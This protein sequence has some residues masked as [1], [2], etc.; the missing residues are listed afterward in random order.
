[1]KRLIDI[2][3]ATILL[4][5]LCP[6]FITIAVLIKLETGKGV[7]FKQSRVGKKGAEFNIYKFRSMHINA[8]KTGPYFTTENDVRITKIGKKLRKTS[9]DELPQLFNVLKGDM[10]LIGPRPNVKQQ[11]SLYTP[12]DWDL[13]NSVRPGIT[14][15]AQVKFRSEAT[16]AQRDELDQYYVNNQSTL[17]DLK[18][19][20]LTFKHLFSMSGN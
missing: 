19:L 2:I 14:G 7:F 3:I 4:I 11:K 18:I 12:Q 13:R 16:P 9:V 10:S 5:I 6:L 1:M 8:E 17:L 20:L 15:L